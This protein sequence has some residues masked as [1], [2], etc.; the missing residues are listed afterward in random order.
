MA[1]PK[2]R[3]MSCRRNA[4]EE[5]LIAACRRGERWA[6]R[7]LF[8]QHNVAVFRALLALSGDPGAAEDFVQETFLKAYRAIGGFRG[9]SSVRTWLM[10]IGTNTFFEDRR[11]EQ[12]RRR[13]LLRIENESAGTSLRL[14]AP[15]GEGGEERREFRDLAFRG[16]AALSATDRTVLTLH[17]LEGYRYAEIAEILDVAPGTVGSRLSRARERLAEAI[18]GLLGL[19]PEESLTLEHLYG[20]GKPGARDRRGERRENPRRNGKK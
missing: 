3:L 13:H 10:R 12:A 8:E 7:D 1:P 14:V 11:R 6:Q 20:H 16:L 9:H 4:G 17:D 18:R 2:F 19:D 15:G 5:E